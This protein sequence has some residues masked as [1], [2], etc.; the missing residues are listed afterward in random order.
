[1]LKLKLQYFGHLLQKTDSFEKTHMLGKI[2]GRKRRGWQRMSITDSMVMNLSQIWELAMDREAWHSAVHWVARNWTQLN[3]WTELTE[4][5]FWAFSY[6]LKHFPIW[7]ISVNFSFIVDCIS[8]YFIPVSLALI[9]DF[10]LLLV[11]FWL[12]GL[13]DI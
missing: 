4:F 8:P 11:H 6:I 2:E 3:D 10:W 9:H 5:K 12:T 7:N 1:M 13:V